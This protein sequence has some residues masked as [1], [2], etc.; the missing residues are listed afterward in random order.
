MCTRLILTHTSYIQ[1]VVPKDMDLRR[2][3]RRNHHYIVCCQPLLAKVTLFFVVVVFFFLLFFF[4]KGK[5]I[6]L[7]QFQKKMSCDSGL[8]NMTVRGL[9]FL[10]TQ[11]KEITCNRLSDNF[12][13]LLLASKAIYLL[14]KT[15]FKSQLNSF[16]LPLAGT[17]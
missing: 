3:L 1:H 4:S 6:I 15:C 2:T 8:E 12:L 16:Y 17:G 9:V 5:I 14:P 10:E 7:I 11:R 13:D